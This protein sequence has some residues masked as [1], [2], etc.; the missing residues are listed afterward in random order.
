MTNQRSWDSGPDSNNKYPAYYFRRAFTV[1]DPGA[2]T[3]FAVDL[4]RDDGAIVYLNGK[5]LFRDNMP[6]GLVQHT[7]YASVAVGGAE[8]SQVYTFVVPPTSLLAGTNVLAVEVHQSG[9]NSTDVSFNLALHAR[10]TTAATGIVIA[11]NTLIRARALSG[12]AWSALV[13]ARFEIAQAQPVVPGQ[14]VISEIHY[15]PEGP[16]NCEFIELWNNSSNLADLT[17]ARLAGGVDFL[18]P[19][20]FRIPPGGCALVVEDAGAFAVRYNPPSRSTPTRSWRWPGRGPAD[21]MT[22]ENGS[23]S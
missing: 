20:G 4:V 8:E 22:A 14:I 12:T 7:D 6:P 11:D 10:L 23:R 2:I 5:E 16:D 9:A 15:N 17:G 21:S 13:E 19:P 1:S 3:E 18:F